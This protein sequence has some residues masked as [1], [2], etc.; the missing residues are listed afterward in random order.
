MG[1]YTDI[2]EFVVKR[3]QEDGQIQ[4]GIYEKIKVNFKPEGRVKIKVEL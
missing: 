2:R 4:N 3:L 1:D